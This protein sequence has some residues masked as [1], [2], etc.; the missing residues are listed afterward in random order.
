MGC[1]QPLKPGAQSPQSI[2]IRWEYKDIEIQFPKDGFTN[3]QSDVP[4]RYDKVVPL[5]NRIILARI[6]QEGQDGWQAD[7]P[8]DFRTLDNLG[9]VKKRERFSF[10]L[11]MTATRT[12]YE[13]ATVRLKRLSR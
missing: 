7:G 3:I 2:P 8:T 1:G 6:Q 5:A 10:A 4:Q 13:S 11:T 9:L 12:T